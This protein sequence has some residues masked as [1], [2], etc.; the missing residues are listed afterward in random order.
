[1]VLHVF[2]D[3]VCDSLHLILD[4]ICIVDGIELDTR[5]LHPPEVVVMCP[6]DYLI[7]E[8]DSWN[9]RLR[10]IIVEVIISK[11]ICPI[12]SLERVV[13]VCLAK[14]KKDRVT[15]SV[16]VIRLVREI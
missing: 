8:L 13:L 14:L 11:M 10:C 15:H 3:S 2:P 4:L 5:A 12:R 7:V 9:G 16:I 1:M 6:P